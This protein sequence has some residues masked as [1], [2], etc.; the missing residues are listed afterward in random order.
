M[1][2]TLASI[3]LASVYDVY[4]YVT[5]YLIAAFGIVIDAAGLNLSN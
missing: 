4:M 2:I 5:R 3:T 1:S